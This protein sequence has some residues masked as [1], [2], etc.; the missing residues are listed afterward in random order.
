[1]DESLR[2]KIWNC[3]CLHG[4]SRLSEDDRG[5]TYRDDNSDFLVNLYHNYFKWSIDEIPPYHPEAYNIIRT[6]FFG[7]Q[8]YEV[9]DLVDF[10]LLHYPR[11]QMSSSIPCLNTSLTDELAGYRIVHGIVAPI[12]SE[13]EI[14]AIEE[15]IS[16]DVVSVRQQLEKALSLLS[17]KKSPHYADSVKNSISAVESLCIAIAAD[18]SKTLPKSLGGVEKR[19]GLQKALSKSLD[20][21]YGYRNVEPGVGHGG[22]KP[23]TVDFE[24]AK[25]YLVSCSAWINYLTAKAAKAGVSLRDQSNP[26]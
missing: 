25:F 18:G 10:A 26:T 9:Y 22:T 14:K 21:L 13:E 17:D 19:V 12:T 20:S 4:F 1:M 3:L 5:K 11:N 7:C 2:H 23:D 24:E 8:W 6:Y 15:A 16:S